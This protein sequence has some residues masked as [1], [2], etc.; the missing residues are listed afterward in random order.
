P[1]LLH[2]AVV[3]SSRTGRADEAESLA[4]RLTEVAPDDPRGW[5][6]LG[7]VLARAHRY[8]EA[9]AVFDAG[10]RRLPGHAGLR[11]QLARVDSLLARP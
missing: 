2:Q 8:P 3:A 11:E 1:D 4:G 5:L 10:R 7:V 6:D 9:R